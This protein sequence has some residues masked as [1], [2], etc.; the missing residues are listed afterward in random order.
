MYFDR[1]TCIEEYIKLRWFCLSPF[2]ILYSINKETYLFNFMYLQLCGKEPEIENAR[3]L[4][5]FTI[6]QANI[7]GA[8]KGKAIAK[9]SYA[10]LR[11][12]DAN[13]PTSSGTGIGNAVVPQPDLVVTVP[14]PDLL[15]QGM[16]MESGGY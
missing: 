5:H 7:I 9:G 14:A 4:L 10:N 15:P 12:H 11:N 16:I 2:F 1:H 13:T 6:L 3:M 8:P